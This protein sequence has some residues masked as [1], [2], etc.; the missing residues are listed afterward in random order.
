MFATDSFFSPASSV[1]RSPM[2]TLRTPFQ[3]KSSEASLITPLSSRPSSPTSSASPLGSADDAEGSDR[4]ARRRSSNPLVLA[5]AHSKTTGASIVA[6]L[7]LLA[8]FCLTAGPAQSAHLA[9]SSASP[10]ARASKHASSASFL[11]FRAWPI[12]AERTAADLLAPPSARARLSSHASHSLVDSANA[13]LTHSQELAAL[14]LFLTSEA[15]HML[16]EE[17]DPQ[18]PLDPDLVLDMA[19]S[20]DPAER[21]ADLRAMEAETWDMTP[22]VIL[23]KRGDSSTKLAHELLHDEDYFGKDGAGIATVYVDRR[24]ASQVIGFC[25]TSHAELTVF[26]PPSA[27]SSR[28][29][30]PDRH[31]RAPDAPLVAAGRPRRWRPARRL[32]GASRTAQ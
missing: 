11:S 29:P 31:D 7:I 27:S 24:C 19:L 30:R 21:E 16:P 3:R 32:Q 20:T 17:L 13:P 4:L 1:F 25:L 14:T 26:S 6:A 10:N 23:G 8:W 9:P 2:I 18:L 12:L 5:K 15:T 22:V 28:H